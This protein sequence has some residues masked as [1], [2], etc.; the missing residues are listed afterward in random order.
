MAKR[1]ATTIEAN[2]A[3]TSYGSLQPQIEILVP[4]GTHYRR[5]NALLH[6]VT[7][8][9]ELRTPASEGWCVYP[10][11]HSEGGT[12]RLELFKATPAE[13][14]RGMKLLQTLVDFLRS[15]GESANILPGAG[16]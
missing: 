2:L 10:E 4:Q 15:R 14:E 5:I 11:A 7:A 3:T 13:A 16:R 8:E 1:T 6:Q 12:V 9:I